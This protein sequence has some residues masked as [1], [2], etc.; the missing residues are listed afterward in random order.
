MSNKIA[1]VFPGQGSQSVGMLAELATQYSIIEA[2]FNEASRVLGFN[3]WQIVQEGPQDL[4]NKTEIT[5]P[6][7]LAASVA[8]WRVLQSEKCPN[9]IV[10]A[11][12]SLGEYSAL[13]CANSLDFGAAIKLVAERGR[14]MQEAVPEGQG[15]MAALVGLSED[16]V[17]EICVNAAQGKI[18]SPA[19]YNADGQIVI[20]GE[21]DAIDRAIALAGEAGAKIAKRIPVS[22]PSH[23]ALMQPAAE[24]LA[25]SLAKISCLTPQIPVINNIDVSI[26]ADTQAIKDALIKQ[27]YSSVRWVET[28]QLMSKQGIQL[29]IECG[30]GKVLAGLNK[31]IEPTIPTISINDIASLH[32][33]IHLM[34]KNQEAL[35]S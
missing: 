4:L 17:A 16:K 1:Y 15:A 27:L 10:M 20:A 29:I 28:I 5:Q 32:Q 7:L 24:R 6:A 13:V 3:L 35:C 31:R 18:L 12:H 2:T 22:V 26:E 8:I 33:A 34:T 23:C 14:F 19:N 11:G 30:P 25:E 21:S 9:P